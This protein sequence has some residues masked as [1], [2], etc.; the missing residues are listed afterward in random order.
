MAP[1]FESH[2]E[3]DVYVTLLQQTSPPAP[4]ALLKAALIRRAMTD[5]QRALRIREDKPALQNLLQKGSIGDDLWAS[6]LAAE[7]ELEAEVLDVMHEAN[8]FMPGWGQFI[9]NTA[10]EMVQN[11]RMKKIFDEIPQT[12]AEFGESAITLFYIRPF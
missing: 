4:D 7:K 3:R 1:Y 8:S 12:K 6:L 10:G 2:P 11:E 9:F 5:V